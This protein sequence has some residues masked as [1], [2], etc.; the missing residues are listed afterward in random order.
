MPSHLATVEQQALHL[1]N[2]GQKEEAAQ[3]FRQILAER[4]DWEHGGAAYDLASCLEDM[5]RFDQAKLYYEQAIHHDGRNPN[6][7]GGYAS[8]LY[9]HG[10]PQEAFDAH[11]KL[12]AIERCSRTQDVA[13]EIIDVLQ[14]LAIK[15]G[16]SETEFNDKINSAGE[17][18]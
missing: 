13:N 3:L 4:P 16:I 11:L 8:F 15:L 17:A 7:W 5:G 2:N 10:E 6:F 1:M 18:E 12:L 14:L 9:L